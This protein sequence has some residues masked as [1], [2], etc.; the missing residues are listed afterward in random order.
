MCRKK[1]IGSLINA[2]TDLA[3]GPSRPGP[4]LIFGKKKKKKEGGR[5]A[6]RAGQTTPAPLPSP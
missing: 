2:A 4:L 3:E 1:P 5:R 6:G